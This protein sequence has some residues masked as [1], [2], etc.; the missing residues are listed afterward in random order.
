MTSELILVLV[1]IGG[2]VFLVFRSD[3]SN[4]M[5]IVFFGDSLTQHA[6]LNK[7]YITLMKKMLEQ[8]GIINYDLVCAGISGNKIYDL[9]LRIEED[10]I[11]K[12]PDIVLVFIGVND[13]WQKLTHNTGTDIDK[14]EKF[15]RAI[16]NKLKVNNIKVVL[17]TPALIGEKKNGFNDQDEELDNYCNIVRNMATEFVLPIVDIR[18]ACIE[19]EEVN[20]INNAEKG[21]LTIDGVHLNSRGNQIVAELMWNVL[22]EVK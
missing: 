9:Y 21:L 1:F 17:C 3:K 14:F 11:S 20:N 15:Y 13:V 10:V 12:S 5:K 8:S 19:Y 2:I 4:K 22:K 18:K 16:I 6:I 7:G